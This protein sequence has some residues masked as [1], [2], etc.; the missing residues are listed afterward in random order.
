MSWISIKSAL[1]EVS[2]RYLV[3]T[4]CVHFAHKALAYNYSHPC[5]K[6][7]IAYYK[8]NGE[9]EYQTGMQWDKE[10][11]VTHWMPLPEKPKKQQELV[12]EFGGE[13]IL[14]KTSDGRL[15][16]IVEEL[17]KIERENKWNL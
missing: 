9:W 17:N 3:S 4:N 2:G 16:D 12:S 11:M 10:V 8:F 15:V 7:N 1:P 13:K 6:V 14:A 5:G